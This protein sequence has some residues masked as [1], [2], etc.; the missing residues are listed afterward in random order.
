MKVLT[1]NYTSLL[2]TEPLYLNA[3]MAKTGVIET[4]I[5][6]HNTFSVFDILDKLA[7]DV[8]ICHFMLPQINDVLKYL[9]S[10]KKIELV[11]NITGM[12][13]QNL[14]ML[15][16]AIEH[17]KIQCPFFINNNH[18]LI[19][20]IKPQKIKILNLIPGADIFLA[21][22]SVPDYKIS[23]AVLSCNS[24]ELF[25]Q[26]C[27][28][29]KVYH[30]L[31]MNRLNEKEDAN[32]DLDVN[33]IMLRS[34]Y[35]KYDAITIVDNN[36]AAFSQVFFDSNLH[37]KKTV[38]K[39]DDKTKM[40]KILAS[41]FHDDEN[42]KSMSDLVKSQIKKKH[43]CLNRTAKLL[44]ELKNEEAAKILQYIGDSL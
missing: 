26:E 44:R 31:R 9:T 32:F 42:G 5:W 3:S 35:D 36:W 23:N 38:L 20:S 2:S 34:L 40:D 29:H 4:N 11:V 7:P 13:E 41:L 8:F 15:E 28:K 10:N 37:G 12:P 6:N 30:K 22:V 17:N 24:N 43:T 19:T 16:T 1:Q 25:K 27:A 18:E 33:I 21:P 39:T 14:A